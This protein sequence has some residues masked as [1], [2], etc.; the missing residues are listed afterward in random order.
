MKDEYKFVVYTGDLLKIAAPR[1]QY[2]NLYIVKVYY[3]S[4]KTKFGGC[5]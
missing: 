3:A 2:V 1:W 4:E 5:G